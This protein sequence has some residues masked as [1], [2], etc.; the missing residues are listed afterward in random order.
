MAIISIPN[1]IGG[2]SIPGAALNGPLGSLFG[3][4]YQ[5]QSLKYPRDLE[6][7]TRGHVVKIDII[8]RT[9]AGYEENG[10]VS[11][12]TVGSG[13]KNQVTGL[14]TQA[15]NAA[16]TAFQKGRDALTSHLPNSVSSFLGTGKTND[17][18]KTVQQNFQQ[19]K[20]KVVTTL[21]LYMPEGITFSYAAN[22]SETNVTDI[23][24]DAIEKLSGNSK[25]KLGKVLSGTATAA[26][27]SAAKIL[28]QKEGLAINPNQQVLFDG[29]NLRTYTLSFTFTP[30]S[31]QE[32]DNVRDI[33]KALKQYSRPRLVANSASMIFIPPMIFQPRFL[34]NGKDNPNISK[35]KKSVVENVEVNYTPNGFATHTDG[36]PVQTTV[37]VTF[38]EIELVTYQ[39]IESGY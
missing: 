3:N 36:A 34:F 16:Q 7:A 32:S 23:A 1:S 19:P 27:S 2:V 37:S 13:I 28:L 18:Q 31:K 38:K 5:V 26:N 17:G 24:K 15:A 10:V 21:S 12:S 39:D 11:L 20:D 25:S 8:D 6:S 4:K 33:I 30:Y 35:V 14:A 29:L 9:P 22:Y